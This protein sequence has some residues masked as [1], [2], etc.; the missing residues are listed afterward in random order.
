MK[1]DLITRRALF[2]G[3]CIPIRIIFAILP[4][5]DG[6]LKNF[7]GSDK[8]VKLFYKAMAVLL[9]L[10]SCGFFYLYYTNGR[11]NALEGG[12]N[13]WWSKLRLIHGYL[14][15]CAA[16]YIYRGNIKYASIP[17][18]IDVVIGL[19]GYLNHHYLHYF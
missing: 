4:Q 2:F 3:L 7:F 6:K 13:T 9:F 8:S 11:L 16:I 15:T 12:E 1:M 10:I 5:I 14:Y 17:L 18:T 19:I